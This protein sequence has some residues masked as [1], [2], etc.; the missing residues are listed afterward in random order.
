MKD[1]A[2]AGL[3]GLGVVAAA[4]AG[5]LLSNDNALGAL[6]SGIASGW[7]VCAGAV[8]MNRW[9]GVLLSSLTALSVSLYLGVQHAGLADSICSV[10]ATFDC[11]KVNTST[12]SELF[13][14]PVATLGS[15][16]YAAVALMAVL[17]LRVGTAERYTRAAHLVAFGGLVSVGY[18]MFL[19][20]ASAT[21]GAWCLFCISL[22][23]LNALILVASWQL[24]QAT[25]TG[26]LAGAIDAIKGK[27]D[28]SFGAMVGGGLVVLVAAMWWNGSPDAPPSTATAS[29]LS[30][31]FQATE[32]PVTLDGTEAALGPVSAP[33][34]VLEFADLECPSCA[35]SFP[36]LVTFAKANP[37]VRVLFKHY[38]ISSLCNAEVQG[39]R[40]KNSC[41]AAMAAECAREQGRFWDLTRLMFANQRDLDADGRGFMARQVGLD[42]AA[43][44][45]CLARPDVDL[46]VRLDVSHAALV[47]VHATPSI[48]LQGISGDKWVAVRGGVE[49]MAALVD[50]H[51]SGQSIPAI[52]PATPHDH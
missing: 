52:P 4:G 6:V 35:A 14:I 26:I 47:G 25:D 16:F 39:E 43:F 42:M 34:T 49:A 48:Y 3:V 30:K 45:A 40:H 10:S 17:A 23:G 13:G 50:A 21:L 28:R 36:K 11:D 8:V 41:A 20:W 32:G 2:T 33:Y 51:R 1:K 44:E 7:L 15:G 5:V 29:D 12:Y 18:S 19:A 9:A 22:Y 24:T 38:P 37:D 46:G 27:N 31:L